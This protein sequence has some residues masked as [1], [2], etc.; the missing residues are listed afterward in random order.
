MTEMAPLGTSPSS[1]RASGGS[2]RTTQFAY[3][4]K[5][6]LPAPF[7]EIRARGDEGLV[8]WDGESMGELEVRGAWIAVRLLRRRLDGRPLDGRRL[9]PDRRHRHHR[10]ERLH[11]DP[12]PR[13]GPRQVG[14]RVDL[15]GRAR[16]RA[17]GPPGRGRGGRDRRARREVGRAAARGR[18]P[19]ARA[20]PRRRRSSAPSSSRSSRSGGCRTRTSSWTRSR[21]RPSASSARRRCGSSSRRHRRPPSRPRPS[22]DPRQD[23]R[24]HRWPLRARGGHR[25]DAGGGGSARRPRRRARDGRDGRGRCARA[26]AVL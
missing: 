20:R 16:E 17:H 1:R 4:A 2:P 5:Q 11:R 25:R 9:V 26:R 18:R 6:G 23:V 10:A 22:G 3:R 14:R 24:R 13:E 7:V 21:R 15:D 12:G 19:E 8:P